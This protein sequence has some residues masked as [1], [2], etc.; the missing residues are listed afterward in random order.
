MNKRYLL[1]ALI[2]GACLPLSA[3]RFQPDPNLIKNCPAIGSVSSRAKS[4]TQN[5]LLLL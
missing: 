5:S 4:Q 3:D 1:G 2:L